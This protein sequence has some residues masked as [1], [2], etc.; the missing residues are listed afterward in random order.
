MTRRD[1]SLET[2]P[3]ESGPTILPLM[4]LPLVGSTSVSRAARRRPPVSGD[5]MTEVVRTAISQLRRRLDR[6]AEGLR[7]TDPGRIVA[8][9]DGDRLRSIAAEVDAISQTL[10]RL[11]DLVSPDQPTAR[12]VS[13]RGVLEAVVAK[14]HHSSAAA[15]LPRISL[16][17]PEGHAVH[18]DP[19]LVRRVLETLLENAVEAAGDGGEVVV[20][21]VEYA[22]AIEIEVADS[23][24]GLTSHA[25]AWIFEP[26]FTTK[27]DGSGVALASASSLVDQLGGTI[28]AADCPD[29]GSAFTIRL[30]HGRRRLA[31]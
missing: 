10:V 29:G 2:E 5:R 27:A 22:D 8:L 31:A 17:V 14:M 7:E 26:G 28:D 19:V 24:P 25:R 11:G 3:D 23:G 1:D 6:L 21:S 13:P 4:G 15:S 12:W 16:D 9:L 20:T 18:A 30:P